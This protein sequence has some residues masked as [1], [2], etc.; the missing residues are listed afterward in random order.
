MLAVVMA[1]AACGPASTAPRLTLAA[2]T[3]PREAYHDLLPLFQTH[4]Q[5]Q[6]G[7]WVEVEQAY[8]ASGA[9]SRALVG[10]FDADVAALALQPDIDRLVREGLITHA[11]QAAPF[12]GM[13]SHS[14]V[15][16]GVRAGNPLGLTDWHDLARPEVR[17]LM[18]NPQTSGGAMWAVLALFGAAQRGAVRGVPA[19]DPQAAQDFVRAVLR[20]VVVM[21]KGARESLITFEAGVGDVILTYE[22]E[23]I[24]GQHHGYD[25]DYIIPSATLLVETPVAL[26]DVYV[27]ERGTRPQAEAFVAFLFTPPAQAVFARHGFRSPDPTVVMTGFPPAGQVF[28]LADLG[29]WSAA[30]EAYFGPQGYYTLAA[31]QAAQEAAP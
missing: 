7:Q 18:A 1:V 17:V 10:G 30:R 29:G 9:Q 24:A 14:L 25:Y 19:N 8:L 21:D 31:Q 20:N 11:W 13:V 5:A 15:V 28:T 23:I 27:D 3:A 16:M 6:T 2:Y 4:Y 26:V 22:N 12:G